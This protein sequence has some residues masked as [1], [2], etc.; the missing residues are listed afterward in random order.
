MRIYSF[1]QL[2]QA[3][4]YEENIQTF[5]HIQNT[6]SWFMSLRDC[7]M[8]PFATSESLLPFE[9]GN[10][11]Q[12]LVAV[13]QNTRMDTRGKVFDLLLSIS[14]FCKTCSRIPPFPQRD[15]LFSPALAL[16]GEGHRKRKLWMVRILQCWGLAMLPYLW[17]CSATKLQ[18]NI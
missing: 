11:D 7:R 2:L 10:W 1:S 9:N 15:V 12:G 17:T 4:N 3:V 6:W 13:L 14:H 16:S 18:Y 5:V 8:Q